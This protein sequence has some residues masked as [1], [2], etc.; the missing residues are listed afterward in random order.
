MADIF[1]SIPNRW[2]KWN[3]DDRQLAGF[4]RRFI[5]AL[6]DLLIIITITATAAAYLGLGE[7]WRMLQMIIH[8]EQVVAD[9]GTVVSSLIPMPVATFI[10]VVGIIIPW[11]YYALLESS[12]NQATLGK[13]AFRIHVS[14]LHGNRITFAR[15]TLRHFSKFLSFFLMLTGFVCIHYTAYKQGL[16]DV[17]AA[18]LIWY[19]KEMPD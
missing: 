17:I 14:D 5:A 13:M 7:G 9:D 11:L 18:C 4:W 3:S 15:A 6:I 10:L 16:H 12:G 8:R 1:S 2:Q 19:K